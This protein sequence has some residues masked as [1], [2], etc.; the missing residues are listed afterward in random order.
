MRSV[1]L[2]VKK[3]TIKYPQK[4]PNFTVEAGSPSLFSYSPPA[5]LD[6]ISELSS[7]ATWG[8]QPNHPKGTLAPR[9]GGSTQ[10]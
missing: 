8:L 6:F 3:K 5:L 4:V 10:K 7:L 1:F 2:R 9:A